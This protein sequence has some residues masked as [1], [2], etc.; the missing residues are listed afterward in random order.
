MLERQLA[1]EEILVVTFTEAATEELRDRLRKRLRSAL[2]AFLAGRAEDRDPL[3]AGLLERL[4]DHGAA[5]R[6]LDRALGSFDQAAVFTIHGFCR[7][8]LQENPFESGS[9]FDTEL[10]TDTAPLLREVAEDFWRRHLYKAPAA[11]VRR[12]RE[13]KMEPAGLLQLAAKRASDP[14]LALLPEVELPPLPADREPT[15]AEL[16]AWLPALRREF[17]SFLGRELPRRKRRANVRFFEDLL[18]DLYQALAGEGGEALAA[19]LRGRYR[20]ALIDEFQDT[21]PLQFRIFDVLWPAVDA[22]PLFLIGD[23]KQAIY[24]FRGADIF[25]YLAAA[26][27]AERH[28][29]LGENWRSEPALIRGV[30]ALFA[31]QP[32]PFLLP[33]IEFTPAVPAAAR[34]QGEEA[35]LL[36]MAGLP[37]PAPLKLWFI[38]RT[39]AGKP[40]TKEELGESLPRAVAGEI[41]RLLTAGAA[42]R[43]RIGDEPLQP[44]HIAVLVRK[45]RQARLV[46]QALALLDIPAV[47]AG[48]GNLFEAE[49]PQEILR[50]LEAVAE[51][52]R[53]RLLRAALVTDLV[54]VSGDELAR[55]LA[56]E[57]GWERVHAEFREYRERWLA[58]GCLALALLLFA[59]RGVRRRLLGLADGE[60]RLTNLLHC[61]E[62]LHTIAVEE[63]LGP[64]GMVAWLAARIAEADKREEHEIRLETDEAAVQLVTVH[65]SKGLEYPV[66]FV[67]FAWD[68]SSGGRKDTALFHDGSGRLTLD[69]GSPE[70]TR[71]QELARAEERA[72]ALRLLY[73]AVTRARHRCYLAWGAGKDAGGS[74]LH[75]LLH[76]A[77][78]V[79]KGQVTLDDGALRADLE[80]LVARSGGSVALLDLPTGAGLPW[81]PPL[82]STAELRC[83]EFTGRIESTW[84]VTSFTGFA[85]GAEHPVELPERDEGTTG[86]EPPTEAPQPVEPGSIHAFPRGTR[87]GIFLHALFEELDFSAGADPRLAEL[88]ARRLADYGYGA[89]W[90]GAV[91]GMVERVL[92]TPLPIPGGTLT[93]GS[94]YPGDWLAELEFTLPLRFLETADFRE[95]ARQWSGLDLP[96]DLEKL[97]AGLRFAP[98]Q[99]MIKGFIDLVFTAGGRWYLADWK[100]NHLGT[101]AADYRPERLQAE[102]A[103]HLYPLQYLLYALALHRHLALRLPGYDYD[104]HFGGVF[105]VFLR[106][107]DPER[108]AGWGVF[109]DRP[110]RQLITDLERL[111][112][113]CGGES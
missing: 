62:L 28:H 61:F 58:G 82:L 10:V 15:E 49:E 113:A 102:L 87:A 109:S 106:G 80:R 76:P 26:R 25:A 48:A 31:G 3:A 74:S 67:P 107:V 36:T 12:V 95:T 72:E 98:V 103:R 64:E 99:G 50:F 42:G 52:G 56:D 111:L 43:L 11:A 6:L 60:R 16:A 96:L 110:P 101:T 57:A 83:R 37:D 14:F 69:L 17:F 81:N 75:H 79:V 44:A 45:H 89:D 33:G 91:V 65:R 77:A 71:H 47:L 40:L 23:P 41:A 30:N 108:E 8:A 112:V 94:L 55:L 1:V 104:R 46:Q 86:G 93:L 32:L 100:S 78:P 39:E 85:S 21:D 54:G 105:Y 88:A 63:Q 70:L 20:A 92:R 2:D 68:D 66:V 73:V 22:A 51:P 7:R 90:Q 5:V 18:L 53:E 59:R 4:P 29:T 34:W 84:R 9:R 97:F 38:P 13:A 19:A 27:A 35:Q 24:S